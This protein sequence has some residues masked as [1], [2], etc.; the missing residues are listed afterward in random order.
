MVR[1]SVDDEVWVRLTAIALDRKETISDLFRV[2]SDGVQPS[3]GALLLAR[4]AL[5]HP[6]PLSAAERHA[7]DVL[8]YIKDSPRGVTIADVMRH[9][10]WSRVTAVAALKVLESDQ[11][12]VRGYIVGQQGAPALNYTL[13]T[14]SVDLQV[15][16][17]V[18][19]ETRGLPEPTPGGKSTGG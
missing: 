1:V 4:A 2:V 17:P 10:L 7:K 15:E 12:V 14:S 13:R 16:E 8:E 11:S 18:Q 5:T 9:F 6:Q 19:A 3:A